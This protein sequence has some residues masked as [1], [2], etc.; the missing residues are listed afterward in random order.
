MNKDINSDK[1]GTTGTGTRLLRSAAFMGIIIVISKAMG[2]LRDIMIASAYGT[3]ELAIAYET[4]SKLPITI[5]DFIL[6]GVVTSAFIPV[7]NSIAVKKSKKDAL[8]FAQTYLN[9]ILLIT[10]TLAVLGIVFAP[11]LVSFMAPS[12][13]ADTAALAASLT[14]IMFPMII[15]VGIAFS[16]VGFLQS[17]GEYNIPALISL[18]SN[19]LMVA[20]L[21]F[22]ND[23]F[24]VHGLSYAM[25]I[26]WGVQAA[27]QIPAVLKRGLRFSI[28]TRLGTPEIARAAKNT[29]P[30]LIATWTAPVCNLI[31]TRIA[32][33]IEAGRAINALGYANRLYIIIVG[34]FSFVATN[35]LFPHF[36][37]ASAS[38]DSAE[39]ERLT[40]VS[41]KTLVFIIA[42]ISIGVATLATPFVS[43]IYENGIF[44]GSDTA[45]TAE[46]LRCY[47]LGM[48]FAAVGEVLTKMF[49]AVE[50]TK[51]PMY[52]SVIS[53]AANAA[54][55]L[56]FGTRL[57]IGGIAIVS[58]AAAG[59][60][61]LIN[62][63]FAYKMKLITPNL[64]DYLDIVKSILSACVMG[65]AVWQVG[66][67]TNGMTI[68]A[69]FALCVLCGILVY[70][71]AVILLRTDEV[72]VVAGM[73]KNRKNKSKE[74]GK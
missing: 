74:D 61:M 36:A 53:I 8:S 69:S 54:V 34:I 64:G 4:A 15:F 68:G 62:L 13:S 37:R 16:F 27:V 56:I 65:V 48:I 9:F 71:A 18:V 3:T 14:R 73:L 46:A 57:G 24:G 33:G 60:N 5:F 67:L 45:I 26:G 6:G 2:L 7:Y 50:K 19:V 63:I 44:N 43:L 31:N 70:A 10:A 17:E 38:G 40:K 52:S 55:I 51:M 20:Y 12:L 23:K 59:V 30:I 32:S 28:K 11:Q 29:L 21:L 22:F 49:F 1:S 47:S 25:L 58:A 39:R 72:V 35:L 66:R 42:P 41:I